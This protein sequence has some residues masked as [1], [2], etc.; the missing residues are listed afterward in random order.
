MWGPP[1]APAPGSGRPQSPHSRRHLSAQRIPGLTE[2]LG[3]D[4]FTSQSMAESTSSP[5]GGLGFASLSPTSRPLRNPITFP[6]LPALSLTKLPAPSLAAPGLEP[7]CSPAHG[8]PEEGD[9]RC[10]S[11]RRRPACLRLLRRPGGAG[12]PWP[13]TAPSA[14]SRL[15]TSSPSPSQ[16]S[17][18]SPPPEVEGGGACEA[19]GPHPNPARAYLGKWRGVHCLPPSFP[20]KTRTF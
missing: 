11:G 17:L 16:F 4:T 2:A 14:G 10:R 18:T 9:C 8:R 7:L 6:S 1:G 13:G 5:P 12:R 20:S 3:K 19:W 15:S